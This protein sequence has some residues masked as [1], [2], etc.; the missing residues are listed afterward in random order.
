MN[1]FVF[2]SAAGFCAIAWSEAGIVRF[3][4]PSSTAEATERG[5]RR[6][7]SDAEPATPPADVMAVVEAAKRYFAGERIDFSHVALD[8]AG[9]DEFF[10]KIYAAARRVGWGQTTTY[11][12]L[13]KELGAGPEAA[14]DVG[15]A[16]ARNPVPLIIPC[17]R[18]LAAGGKLGGFSAP[19]G[20]VAKQR[21]LEMEGRPA[22]PAKPAQ[23]TLAL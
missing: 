10:R 18:V 16:M 1:Y 13:A 9:Q 2:E 19:G 4:L 6:R 20:S 14:R 22:E 21:M 3:H 7:L 15:Q 11:G 23:G 5:M 8:L 17:H 12:S